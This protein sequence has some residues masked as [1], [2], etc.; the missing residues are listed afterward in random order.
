MSKTKRPDAKIFP[1]E[2]RFQKLAR[3]PGGMPRDSA[4]K[5]AQ[6]EIDKVKP[7]YDQWLERELRALAALVQGAQ[8]GNAQPGWIETANFRSRELRD[9]ATTLGF[10][11]IAFITSSLCDLFDAIEAGSEC[12][13][14]AI[15]CHVDA[16]ILARQTFYRR[17]KPDQVPELTKG[18]RRVT[19]HVAT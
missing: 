9:S 6:V 5:R 11:L 12:N 18:L 16:L 8:S 10:E 2:T 17:L 14:E 1:V 15:S 3:R 19:K 13:V 7:N 4:V